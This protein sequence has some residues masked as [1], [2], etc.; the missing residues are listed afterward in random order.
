MS[1]KLSKTLKYSASLL[2]ATLL[3]YYAFEGVEWKSFWQALLDTRWS[4]VAVS[5][6]FSLTALWL[7]AERW[8]L[9]LL[10]VDPEVKR[11]TVWD[12]YNFG[13][14]ASTFVPGLGEFVR[15]GGVTNK[16]TSF[17][18][19]FGTVMMERAWDFLAI[20]ILAA[21]AVVSE[22]S[23]IVGFL[24]EY[25][26]GPISDRLSLWWIAALLLLLAV[27][28]IMAVVFLK[29]KNA[30]C[31]KVYGWI[32]GVLNGLKSFGQMKNKAL[33]ICHSI[34]IWVS[35]IVVTYVSFLAIPSLAHLTFMDALLISAIGNFASV[36][37]VPGGV[38]AYHYLVALLLSS[39]Y[40][41]S[42]E[43]GILYATLTHEI[44]AIFLISMAGVSYVSVLLRKKA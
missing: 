44:H 28:A 16:K 10:P 13:N 27:A 31:A 36:I 41:A 43:S 8:R 7:R 38:G 1:P 18:K 5:I 15:V 35:Y 17:D 9:L 39:L 25:V 20:G 34:L 32:I 11:I 23:V 4:W 30:F 14:F 2:L 19:G 40:G 6:V 26:L 37:P 3:V 12:S 42:W 24:K 33:F 22:R 29:D 21:I